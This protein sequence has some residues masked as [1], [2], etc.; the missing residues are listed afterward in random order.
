MPA[1][2]AT[3]PTTI[4]AEEADY[5]P[6][7]AMQAS[8]LPTYIAPVTAAPPAVRPYAENIKVRVV[9]SEFFQDQSAP[10]DRLVPAHA[11]VQ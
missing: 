10:A 1:D 4:E 6:S 5:T 9:G 3:L 8:D 2:T 7:A 11:P